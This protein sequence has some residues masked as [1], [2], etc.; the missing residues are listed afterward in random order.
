MKAII[1]TGD[2]GDS[3]DPTAVNPGKVRATDNGARVPFLVWGPGLI[4]QRGLTDELC[5]F[6]DIFPT[7]VDYAGAGLPGGP[8]CPADMAG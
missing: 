3:G 2:N 6:S 1:F 8:R 4:K 5:E 7:L